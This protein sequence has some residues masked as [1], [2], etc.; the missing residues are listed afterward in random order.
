MNQ[1]KKPLRS[2]AIVILLILGLAAFIVYFYFFINPAQVVEILSQTNLAVYAGAFVAYCLYVFFSSLVWHRLLNSV[3]IKIRAR[4]ALLY[5]WVG[6]FF[7]ATVPQ[8]GWSGE[9]SK[10]YLL[11]QDSEAD[12][13]K[14]GASVVGQKI[15]VM[16]MT[17]AALAAGL[18]SILVSY[19]LDPLVTFVIAM[20]LALSILTLGVVYYVSIKPT[21]T[22]TLLNWVVRVVL[23]FRKHWSPENFRVRAEELLGRFHFGI[24]ELKANPK[25]LVLTILF[26][27]VSFV[28]EISV[29]FLSFTALG[30]SVRVDQVLI[31]FTLTG[32]LQ[33]V[34]I[35]FLGFPDVIMATSFTALGIEPASL[36]FS[37]TLLAR[38]VNLWFKLIVSYGALQWAG[39]GMLKKSTAKTA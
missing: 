25:G 32:T 21:A 14:I 30:Y 5:T 27:V 22:K 34:G 39:L 29:I 10:T 36:A 13:A 19:T 7:E 33:T 28:F 38:I 23:V 6:L 37:A 17:V 15:F 12:A 4:K 9:I 1:A 26:S 20:V 24:R 11:S 3:S 18:I 16:T 35:G 8:L 31:V 2:K